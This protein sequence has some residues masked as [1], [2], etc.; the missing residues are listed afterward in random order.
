MNAPLKPV[1]GPPPRALPWRSIVAIVLVVVATLVAPLALA[2]SWMNR[3]LLNTGN[4]VS[5]VAPLASDP[6]VQTAVA[7]SLTDQLWTR[8]DVSGQLSGALPSWAQVF[9]APLSNTLKGYAYQATHAAVSSKAFVT[10][11]KN[12]NRTA[13]NQVRTV[14]LG[15]EGGMVKSNSGQVSLDLAPLADQVKADLDNRGVRVLDPVTLPP[16]RATFVIFHSATLAKAQKIVKVLHGLSVVLPLLLVASW[17]GAVA[18]SQ[19]R[20]RT[21]LQLGFALA[22]AMAVTLVAY[23]LGRG[24]YLNAVSSPQL[25]RAAA[26]SIFDTLMRGLLAAAQTV[27]VV[28]LVIWLGALVA[29]PAG[30]AGKARSAFAGGLDTAGSAAEARGLDLGRFGSWVAR[31]RHTLQIAGL[32]VAAGLLVFW[33]TAGVAGVLWTVALLL[34]Y[35]ALVEFVG[36]LTARPTNEDAAPGRDRP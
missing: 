26:A 13:H 16:G 11:W 1:A 21:I 2:V 31:C 8:V 19:R 5:T 33:G 22:L 18:V 23:H 4:Y 10:V 34:V 27:F 29:G 15:S 3:D 20:R 9:A 30:W 36:R 6:A 24:A 35:V 17:A 7:R 12:A 14:L 28:G 32:V 25:P